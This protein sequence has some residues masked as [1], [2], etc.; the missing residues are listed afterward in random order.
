MFQ[1]PQRSVPD[2]TLKTK[3]RRQALEAF[4]KDL[5]LEG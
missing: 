2:G 1:K 4:R 3:A 5:F